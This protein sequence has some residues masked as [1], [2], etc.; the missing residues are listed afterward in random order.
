MY[1]VRIFCLAYLTTMTFIFV[2]C[3]Q[4]RITDKKD[5][6]E[7]CHSNTHTLSFYVSHIFFVIYY[8]ILQFLKIIGAFIFSLLI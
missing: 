7:T 2:V 8:V 1:V 5:F 4:L 3:V 6:H